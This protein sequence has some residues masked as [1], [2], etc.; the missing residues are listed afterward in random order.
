MK[1]KLEKI[2]CSSATC[3]TFQSQDFGVSRGRKG[4]HEKNKHFSPGPKY[5][6]FTLTTETK[7][8]RK[9][10]IRKSGAYQEILD[11]KLGLLTTHLTS[12]S[13]SPEAR[14]KDNTLTL[15]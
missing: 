6:T 8:A 12:D 7:R 15:Q 5:N 4:R 14:R 9:E 2:G 10:W 11:R 13:P 1:T 3:P